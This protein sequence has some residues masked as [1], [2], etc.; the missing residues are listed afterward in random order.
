MTGIPALLAL[1]ALAAL[2]NLAGGL[3]LASSGAYRSEAKL[4]KYLVALGAGFMLAAIFIEI[5]PETVRLW[6]EGATGA[7]AAEVFVG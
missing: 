5:V 3:L 4:L 2:A 6:T 7:N 1:G